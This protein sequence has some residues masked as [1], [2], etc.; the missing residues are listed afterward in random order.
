VTNA[1][2]IVGG[3]ETKFCKTSHVSF[4]LFTT[5]RRKLPERIL[6]KFHIGEFW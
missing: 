4:V 5:K 3:F 1:S 2:H 6:I